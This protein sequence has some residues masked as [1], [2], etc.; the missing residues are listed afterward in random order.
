MA[1][2]VYRDAAA[3]QNLPRMHA[4][5]N[6]RD[7]CEA[8]DPRPLAGCDD[9]GW[10]KVTPE[11]VVVVEFSVDY[12]SEVSSEELES[13]EAGEWIGL[14]SQIEM[15]DNVDT[16]S[17]TE[18]IYTEWD[19]HSDLYTDEDES[20]AGSLFQEIFSGGSDGEA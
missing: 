9:D 3:H 18:T 14:D 10:L 2:D 20:D 4:S 13:F 16:L 17:D 19:N 8:G 11:M 6:E 1:M 7:L 15:E 12:E 5:D